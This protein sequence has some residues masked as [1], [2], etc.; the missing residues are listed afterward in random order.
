M[1]SHKAAMRAEI[2]RRR[3]AQPDKDAVS[4]WI[5][6]RIA[7]MAEFDTARTV[8]LYVDFGSE[9]RTRTLIDEAMRRGKTVTVP[10]CVGDDLRLFRLESMEELSPGA[11]D[12]P[13]PRPAMRQ[14]TD[15]HVAPSE[16]DLIVVPGIAFDRH[17]RRL[18]QGKGFYDRLLTQVRLDTFL[19][20]PTFE[21]QIVEAVPTL[22]HDAPVHRVV[23]ENNVY[24]N[25]GE[26]PQMDTDKH[27]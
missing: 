15:R 26:E 20:A 10:Y 4:R 3:S 17:C 19:I 25:S 24:S 2:R 12:I 6:E 7:A 13:E 23:T 9:V 18:G 1:K 21:C 5:C 27:R 22:P 16:L 11:Y 8:L 14:Q